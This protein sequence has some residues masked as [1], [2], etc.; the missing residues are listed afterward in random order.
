MASVDATRR[1]VLAPAAPHPSFTRYLVI[2]VLF[3]VAYLAIN[4]ITNSRQFRESGITLWSPDNGLSL[5][6][7]IESTFFAPIVLFGAIL[8]DILIN[9][10]GHSLY[11]VVASEL[12]LTWG[13]LFIAI[14]LRDVL[15]TAMSSLGTPRSLA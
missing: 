3:L 2:S 15:S 14:V 1:Q 8:S 5:L 13:Y 6:L 11:V 12:L 7:L 4:V 10:V 9:N